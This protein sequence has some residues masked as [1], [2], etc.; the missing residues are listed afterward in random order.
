VR[1]AEPFDGLD[2]TGPQLGEQILGLFFQLVDAVRAQEAVCEWSSQPSLRV[3]SRGP[4]VG[5]KGGRIVEQR[6]FG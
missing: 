2:G 4:Q 6:N 1:R 3:L 5:Q